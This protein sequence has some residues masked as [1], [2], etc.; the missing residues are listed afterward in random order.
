MA[1]N[2]SWEAV[3]EGALDI[4]AWRLVGSS[5]A[6]ADFVHDSRHERWMK[7]H[8]HSHLSR[9]ILFP[10]K[11]ECLYGVGGKAY[12]CRPGTVFIFDSYE[13]HDADYR[14]GS[15]DLLHVWI[16]FFEKDTIARMA[17]LEGGRKSSGKAIFLNESPQGKAL[18]L[19]WD[20]FQRADAPLRLRR[21]R[22][23]SGIL[24]LLLE[25]VE[26]DREATEPRQ[27]DFQKEVVFAIRHHVA[28]CVGSGGISLKEAAKLSG[29]SMYHFLRLY[30][31]H[32]GQAFHDYVDACRLKKVE[33]MLKEQC[34]KREIAEALGFSHLSTFSRWLKTARRK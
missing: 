6:E 21:L 32:T 15:G 31:R 9:E 7:T 33:A 12:P 3:S 18:K 17:L 8:S 16:H 5:L 1:S 11:G 4:A 30:K 14:P 22:M 26:L 28:A 25:A 2:L 20:G 10:L 34:S 13:S 23:L 19:I 27:K 29:Y 24:S